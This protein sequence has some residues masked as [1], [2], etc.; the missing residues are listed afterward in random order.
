MK[1]ERRGTS[2]VRCVRA[3]YVMLRPS[4]SSPC[5][6]RFGERESRDEGKGDTKEGCGVGGPGI[7]DK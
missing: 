2:G 4:S 3:G 1:G 6:V 7:V 5:V